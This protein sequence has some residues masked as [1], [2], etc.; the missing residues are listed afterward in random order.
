M[1]FVPDLAVFGL[2][3]YAR[4]SSKETGS[5]QSSP[6][7]AWI[8]KFN[9][10]EI[11][12]LHLIADGMSNREISQKIFLSLDTVKWYNKQLFAKLGVN[13]R[14]QALKIAGRYRLIQSVPDAQGEEKFHLDNSL[15]A[16][17]TSYVGRR[18]EIEEIRT[19]LR[20]NRLVVLTGAGGTGK[21][22]LALETASQLVDTFRDGV[23][24]VDLAPLTKQEQILEALARGLKVTAAGEP[25]LLEIIKKY[26][27]RK[28][29]LLLLDNFEHLLDAAPFVTELLTSAPRLVVLATSRERLRVYGE[30]EY[31][32]WPLSIPDPN[33]REQIQK[34]TDYEAI[35]LFIQRAKA[36][37]PEL[38]FDEENISAAARICQRL[39][40]LPLAIELA[41]SQAKL[42]PL[43]AL[44]RKLEHSMEALPDGPRDVP[45][46][47]RTLQ[48]T[49]GWSY[50]L[51]KTT[52]KRLFGRM[53]VFGGSATL[54]AVE[55]VCGV[56]LTGK[57]S[58]VLFALVNKNLIFTR[59]GKDGE[60]RFW[61]LETI[62]DYSG[63]LLRTS[64][65][66]E[67]LRQRLIEYF[68]DLAEKYEK[69]IHG[70]RH[71]YWNAR[72]HAEHN[73]LT[74]ILES[75]LP[76]PWPIARLRVIA[77]LAEHWFINARRDNMHWLTPALQLA[78][79][80]PVDLRA[81]VL[82]TAGEIY[83]YL[84][85]QTRSEELLRSALALFEQI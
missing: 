39:D 19:L 82:Q 38:D 43:P 26:L 30:V 33:S 8:G 17:L 22:R 31:P 40:G 13:N 18:R 85:D 46:R 9:R 1:N 69:E 42:F 37:R 20:V 59:E 71:V 57:V 32:V 81:R 75:E 80:A 14:T 68:A 78:M 25:A 84:G 23:R 76:D 35:N 58:D 50:D 65:E 52:E 72:M 49:I 63:R 34:L 53:A 54:E 79:D 70:P 61:M 77:G 67:I 41:A 66:Y 7:P 12:I 83:R 24:L 4:S 3:V 74:P 2:E 48:A 44:A 62:R 10:R 6:L 29:V 73:N 36:A 11:E 27:S 51:L 60:L 5:M 56:D 45:A 16:P 55:R 21:T 28:H 15:P 47:Q 64:G